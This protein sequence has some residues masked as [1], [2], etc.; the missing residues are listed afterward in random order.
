M[1][2][3]VLLI[4]GIL[5]ML[6]S[7]YFCVRPHI[8]AV[9]PAYGGLWLLQWSG[10]MAFPSVMMSYWGIMAVVVII[11]V[12]MLPQ[13]VVKATRGM[14]HITVG[15]VAGMLIGATIGYAPM[16]V[17][18]FAGAFAGCM[19]F[20]RTP[21]GK[22]LGLLTSRFVQYFCAKGLPVVVTVSILG[23]A[24]EVAAVQYSNV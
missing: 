9:I 6:S 4:S 23:I 3:V 22:A 20:V 24:I 1:M 2:D 12:S 15:A 17:G 7:L 18:A 16:I 21:K 19:V 11:I 8:P 14:A 13:P 10:M 5:F